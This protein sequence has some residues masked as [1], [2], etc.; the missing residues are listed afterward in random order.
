MAS[1]PLTET[2]MVQACHKPQQP[3]KNHRSGH[4]AEKTGRGF[5]LNCPSLSPNDPIGQ[6]TELNH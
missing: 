4:P 1:E 6:G 3:L 2:C 5:W